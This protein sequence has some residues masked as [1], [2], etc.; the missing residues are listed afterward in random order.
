MPNSKLRQDPHKVQEAREKNLETAIGR[1]VRE[2]RRARGMTGR[3][4][5]RGDGAVG[6]DAVEDRERRDVGVR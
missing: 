4:P 3:R 5:G 1:E 6:G 2:V